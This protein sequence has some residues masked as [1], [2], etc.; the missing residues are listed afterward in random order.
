MK[1][2]YRIYLPFHYDPEKE[3]PVLLFL[4]GAGHRGDDNFAPIKGM[5]YAL[6]SHESVPMEDA[7]L[8]VPQCPKNYQ[9]VDTPWSKGNYNINSIPESKA[10]ACLVELLNQVLTQ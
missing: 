8:L 3:Y 5:P 2:K 10:M 1:M 9:W 4:H 7:I 6:Y